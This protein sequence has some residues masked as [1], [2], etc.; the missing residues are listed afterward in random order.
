MGWV[1][2]LVKLEQEDW[3]RVLAVLSQAPWNV[4]N[5]LI[6]AIGEQLRAQ[7]PRPNGPQEPQG[8][9]QEPIRQ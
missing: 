3:N 9:S 5:P 4:A 6:M 1:M 2:L 7:T 8:A